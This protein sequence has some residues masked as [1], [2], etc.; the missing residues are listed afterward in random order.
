MKKEIDAS[1]FLNP[2]QFTVRVEYKNNIRSCIICISKD[3]QF[4]SAAKLSSIKSYSKIEYS[5]IQHKVSRRRLIMTIKD[6][7]NFPCFYFP[8]QLVLV[9]LFINDVLWWKFMLSQRHCQF[10][11][12]FCPE[13]FSA[14]NFSLLLTLRVNDKSCF[15][16]I[17]I[18]LLK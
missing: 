9:I 10:N 11:S 1:I 16:F 13:A 18:A 12:C 4:W 7:F 14:G 8:S 17:L 6:Q 5:Y 3:C 2:I 15:W